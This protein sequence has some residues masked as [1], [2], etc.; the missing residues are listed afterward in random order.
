MTLPDLVLHSG[1]VF[2]RTHCNELGGGFRETGLASFQTSYHPHHWSPPCH[3]NRRSHCRLFAGFRKPSVNGRREFFKQHMQHRFPYAGDTCAWL[4]ITAANGLDIKYVGV[5]E[6][7][8]EIS[9]ATIERRGSIVVRRPP[10]VIDGKRVP[11][12]LGSN[13]LQ[14]FP[15][16]RSLLN[17]KETGFVRVAGRRAVMVT[18]NSHCAVAVTAPA[19]GNAVVEP[20]SSPLPNNIILPSSVVQASGATISVTVYN[21]GAMG[22]WLLPK[23][24]IGIITRGAV[25]DDGIQVEVYNRGISV[26]VNEVNHVTDD[27]RPIEGLD[28]SSLDD[29]LLQ[30][31]VEELFRKY[32]GVFAAKDDIPGR[33][34]T[35][36]H[37]ITLDGGHVKAQPY[38]RV[39]WT[40]MEELRQ[41][42]RQLLSKD[43]IRPSTSPYLSPVVLVRKKSGELRMC[44]D[45]RG[46]NAK[47]IKDAY[48]LPRIEE[49]LDALNGAALFSTMDIQSAYYQVEI[50]EEDRAKTVFTTPVGLFE[51]NR[52]VF[53]LCNA[54]ATYQRLMQNLFR[55]DIFRVLL[56]Y[57]DD[58][59]VYSRS[60]EEHIERLEMV[61]K[62]L[63]EQGL[64]LELKKCKFFQK[65]VNFLGH[66][67][68][69][70]GVATATDKI[71]AVT[72]WPVPK[73]MKDVRSFL[74]FCSYY[75][76]FVK[77][78]AQLAKPL[79]QLL[80]DREPGKAC[81]RRKSVSIQTRWY[82]DAS[83]QHV[84]DTLQHAMTN[85]PVL[86]FADFNL[87]FVLETD[88]S[89]DGIGAVLSQVQDGK[90]KV[91]A[92]VSRGLRGGEKN[93]DNYS[94]KK[95]ELLS[96]K[97]AVTEKLR[98]YLHGA[99]FTV[100]T[101]NNPLTHVLTQKKLPAL[102]Q[103]RVNAL[104][105]FNFDIKY[106]P[107]KTNANADGLSR[108]PHP[109]EETDVMSSCMASALICTALPM[110]LQSTIMHA[111]QHGEDAKCF[112]VRFTVTNEKTS[113][114][115]KLR[116]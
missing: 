9:G 35:V 24:R 94:S 105:S 40:Q 84:F 86:G 47:T 15:E 39:P 34:R 60:V 12:L 46:L 29:N 19:L 90:S 95:L 13:V 69:T 33:S 62:K 16:F 67:I 38:R 3:H 75:R 100:Y 10:T 25:E 53:G 7:D 71:Q 50:A 58:I 4:T 6:M 110:E 55:D 32:R 88:A 43:I 28:L 82:E 42:I 107:G 20:L 70:T 44:V 97:W 18:A 27:T 45:Y 63:Q 111:T 61:F 102:E 52:M 23:T 72:D 64:K 81:R 37:H 108:K 87:P 30:G 80:S 8:V 114:E 14:H 22:V 115:C 56:V 91:I 104:A 79:H 21:P 11:G 2:S 59:L 1:R 96:L 93:M 77:G 98:D 66:E 5:A 49:S 113:Y 78:F 73:T 83:L 36:L 99:H 103:R 112:T 26:R 65:K 106:R 31:K 54:P 68:S 57:L 85:T 116:M 48:P 101:D 89:N 51:F 92:Y 17:K 41:H 109:V 76:R 74:G